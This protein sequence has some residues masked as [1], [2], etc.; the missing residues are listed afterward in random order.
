[1]SLSAV[2]SVAA[3]KMPAAFYLKAL[4]QT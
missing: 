1:M 4:L 3:R 2:F